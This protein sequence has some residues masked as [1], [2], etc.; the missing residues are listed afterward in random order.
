MEENRLWKDDRHSHFWIE[1]GVL[2]ESYHTIRG[3]RYRNRFYVEGLPDTDRCSP[4]M[5]LRI[6]S[7]FIENI[8]R[9]T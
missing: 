3:L 4:E 8:Q 1:D 5:I 7:E 9:T 2:F 6:E